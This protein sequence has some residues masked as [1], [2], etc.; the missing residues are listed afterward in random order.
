MLWLYP[1]PSRHCR[2]TF[3]YLGE[4]LEA[5]GVAATAAEVFRGAAAGEAI[6]DIFCS[7]GGEDIGE[8][9]FKDVTEVYDALSVEAARD[10][11]AV[12]E[13]A[14]VVAKTVAEY[15]VGAEGRFPIGPFKAITVF[16]VQLVADARAASAPFPLTAKLRLKKVKGSVIPAVV[17]ALVP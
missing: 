13:Y 12:G 6:E 4:G 10:D 7:F 3:P 14:E 8:G 15:L 17:A 9:A 11:G 1:H 2:D 5:S 16:E